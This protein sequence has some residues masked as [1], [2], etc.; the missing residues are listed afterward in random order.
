M[1]WA[2]TLLLLPVAALAYAGW[3]GTRPATGGPTER[4]PPDKPVVLCLGDSLTHGRIGHDWVADLRAR[5][6]EWH[7]VN[8]GIN[9][10]VTWQMLQ[11]VDELLALEPAAVLLLTG[12]N[13]CMASLDRADGEAYRD[14]ND[15]PQVPDLPWFERCL[16]ELLERLEGV[17]TAV[18]TLAPLGEDGVD[19]VDPFNGVI[20]RLAPVVL[21]LNE[22]L[23]HDRGGPGHR[24]RWARKR[25]VLGALGQRYLLGRSWDAIAEARGG[26]MLVD[27][28]HFSDRAAAALL[29]L[30]EP[31][32][33][34]ELRSSSARPSP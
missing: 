14:G 26:W 12:C 21:P 33:R 15:L 30:V 27:G 5:H 16:G 22:R 17:P 24:V 9:G 13:D 4:P 19:H 23:R 3:Q 8:A 29:E 32:L 1:I 6:P 28:I 18:L 34:D 20:R 10:Q 2:L 25:V 11:R 7:V 31:W